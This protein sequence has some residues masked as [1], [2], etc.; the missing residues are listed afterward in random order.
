MY[1]FNPDSNEYIWMLILSPSI[2]I[3]FIPENT[4]KKL[5]KGKDK[6]K[7]KIIEF[8]KDQEDIIKSFNIRSIGAQYRGHSKLK[9]VIGLENELNYLLNIINKNKE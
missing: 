2:A 4:I 3:S 5:S 7:I 6:S 8:R 9:C 1:T